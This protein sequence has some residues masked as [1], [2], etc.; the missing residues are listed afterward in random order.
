M[1][2]KTKE[3][4]P[5]AQFINEAHGGDYFTISRYIDKALF[6]LHYVPEGHFSETEKRNVCFTLHEIKESFYRAYRKRKNR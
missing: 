3:L 4:K 6:M 5:L 2:S 1:K